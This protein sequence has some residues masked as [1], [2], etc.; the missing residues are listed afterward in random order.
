[1]GR[2]HRSR[3]RKKYE[4]NT[5]C[6]PLNYDEKFINLSKSMHQNGWLNETK[7]RIGEFQWI[8][9]GVYSLKNLK[10]IDLIISI[11]IVNFITIHTIDDDIQF[12]RILSMAFRAKEKCIQMQCLLSI[13]LLYVRHHKRWTEYSNTLPLRFD[14]PYFCRS[15]EILMMISEIKE[16]IRQQ[17]LMV[18]EQFKL[19]RDTFG[20]IK[21]D[22][23]GRKYFSEIFTLESFTWAFFAVNSRT[24][25]FDPQQVHT[26]KPRD[27][28]SAIR[29]LKDRPTMALAPFLDLL[30]HDSSADTEFKI[31][32]R[33]QTTFY[34]LYTKHPVNRYKQIFIS[35]GKLDNTK[36]LTEYG[37]F[38]PHNNCDSVEIKRNDLKF[39]LKLLPFSMDKSIKSF[40]FN[41]AKEL[42]VT[43]EN[44]LN[45]NL[46]LVLRA[47]YEVFKNSQVTVVQLNKRIYDV[48]DNESELQNFNEFYAL[49][50]INFKIK[51]FQ[52]SA[53]YFLRLRKLE[54]LSRQGEIYL[55]FLNF[56]INWLFELKNKES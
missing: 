39:L 48:C 31:K 29:Y 6:K 16:K 33:N 9:R 46:L 10:K 34:E 4:A 17:K 23:C 14:C 44:G 51:L 40:I 21:C 53:K 18:N 56:T 15:S 30:N 5:V 11:P 35:Y 3:K 45:Y 7:L 25:Y 52:I 38:L 26:R 12:S 36:L 32:N 20:D 54:K 37:F 41:L 42:Y 49:K 19:F 1:M 22:C 13:Y 2:T 55:D 47:L 24:V 28:S 27:H 50:L 8:G 43:L